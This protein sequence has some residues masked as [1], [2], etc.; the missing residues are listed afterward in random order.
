M[1]TARSAWLPVLDPAGVVGVFVVEAGPESGA[2]VVLLAEPA[3]FPAVESDWAFT[4]P[5]SDS[6]TGLFVPRPLRMRYIA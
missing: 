3:A 5:S 6:L 2:C 4:G 1:S